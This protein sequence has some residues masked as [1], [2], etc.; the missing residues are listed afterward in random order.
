MNV[1]IQAINF[2][3]TEKLKVFIDKKA[4]RLQR[5][6]PELTTVDVKMTVV[7]PESANNKEVVL[8]AV[9]PSNEFVATKTADTFEEAIDLAL[10]ALSKMLEKTKDK[11]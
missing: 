2:V 9:Q 11:K 7:K 3:A 6:H 8:K 4:E 5:H 10:D 1:T